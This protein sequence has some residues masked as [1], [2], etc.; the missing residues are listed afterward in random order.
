MGKYRTLVDLLGHKDTGGKGLL[1]LTDG[2]V[3]IHL[4]ANAQRS[5]VLAASYGEKT[6]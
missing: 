5:L 1:Y 6:V 2:P 4:D 3:F